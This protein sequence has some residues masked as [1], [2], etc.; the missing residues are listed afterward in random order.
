VPL[1]LTPEE[2]LAFSGLIRLLIRADGEFTAEEQF[3]V[4]KVMAEL[5]LRSASPQS[6][7]RSAQG[8]GAAQPDPEATWA[9]VDRAG[10][11]LPNDDA[12]RAAAL[13]VTNPEVRAA[14]YCALQ[15]IAAAD[16]VSEAE[17]PLLDWLA[18]AWEI[19]WS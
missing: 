18:T 19:Q 16:S 8:S 11:E 13:K 1:T 9:L 14:L 5:V 15:E 12:I 7:Y 3:V 10:R 4:E 6:P 2:Q 17:W